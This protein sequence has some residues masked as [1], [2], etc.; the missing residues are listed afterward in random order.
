VDVV[1]HEA[2]GETAPATFLDHEAEDP[3]IPLAVGVVEIDRLLRVAARE[4]VEYPALELFSV[5]PSHARLSRRRQLSA[6]H[7]RGQTP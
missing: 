7:L 3:Q 1:L 6:P 2:V 4:D 5:R